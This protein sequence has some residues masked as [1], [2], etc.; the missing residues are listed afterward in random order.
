[1]D[2]EFLLNKMALNLATE[3]K[4]PIVLSC[5]VVRYEPELFGIRN[6]KVLLS[7]LVSL[8]IVS[9]QLWKLRI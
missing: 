6:D 8:S 9:E 5:S 2:W 3:N 4:K 7:A 1:M